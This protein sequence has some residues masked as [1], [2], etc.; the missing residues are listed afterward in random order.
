MPDDLIGRKLE[1]LQSSLEK[2]ARKLDKLTGQLENAQKD[3]RGQLDALSGQIAAYIGEERAARSRQLA[4][5]AVADARAEYD[6]QFGHHQVVRRGATGMLPAMASGTVR[7]EAFLRAAEQLMIEAPGYWLSTALVALAAWASD[8]PDVT[9]RAVSEAVSR[10]PARSALFFSLVLARFGRQAGAA[11]W[12]GEYAKAQDCDA[13]SGEFAAVLD[14]VARAALGSQARERLLGA[15]RSWQDQLSQSGELQ[16][17]QAASWA[18]FIR[19]QRRPLTDKFQPLETVSR[20][21][22]A[23][24][25]M[26]E[27]AAAFGHTEQWLKGQLGGTGEE[28]EMP[29]AAVGDLLRHLIDMPDQAESPLLDA[30][31]RQQ[32]IVDHDGD[33]SA[34]ADG[35]PASTD[36]LTLSTAIATGKYCAVLS[37]HASRFCLVLSRNPAER[38]LAE[39]SQQ[40][41]STCP[42]SIE[43]DVEGWHHAIEPGSD[44]D[45][46]MQKFLAWAHGAMTA[47]KTQ[48]SRRRLG[49]GKTSTRL[50]HIE[51]SWEALMADGQETVYAATRQANR[52][53]QRWQQE[54]KAAARCIE[55]LQ[56]GPAEVRSDEQEPGRAPGAAGP[57]MKLPDWDPRPL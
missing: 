42:A 8:S 46:L 43:V 31:R 16:A 4:Y 23:T 2:L 48:A 57:A 14:T 39:L 45:V 38:A 17:K 13:L 19:G 41:E 52:F 32:A 26:L 47:D 3:L 9:K 49:I 27:A 36:F 56:A 11:D 34:P 53:F 20:D 51:S 28:D 5:A 35:E 55:L 7:P 21:W 18:E 54:T 10:D 30:V 33:P 29:G 22:R 15:C 50:E 24:L 25:G 12:I 1:N 40:V 37:G 44:P 6:R